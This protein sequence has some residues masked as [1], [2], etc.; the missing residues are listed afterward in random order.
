MTEKVSLSSANVLREYATSLPYRLSALWQSPHVQDAL[1]ETLLRYLENRLA[2]VSRTT[3]RRGCCGLHQTVVR[4]LR[5]RKAARL[6]R[7]E[8]LRSVFRQGNY[9]ICRK[10]M[11]CPPMETGSFCTILKGIQSKSRKNPRTVRE[12]SQEAATAGTGGAADGNGSIKQVRNSFM[13]I[14]IAQME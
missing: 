13:V 2:F 1:Q 7:L 14:G 6:P 10:C 4:C 5:F 12:A 8:P 9:N 11:P 3:K